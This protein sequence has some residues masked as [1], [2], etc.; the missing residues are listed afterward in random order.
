VLIVC[1]SLVLVIFLWTLVVITWVVMQP[2]RLRPNTW[3]KWLA[4]GGWLTFCLVVVIATW[5][6]LDQA[7]SL[8]RT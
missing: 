4:L 7:Y 6:A 3:G 8:I 5:F 2:P 1:Q